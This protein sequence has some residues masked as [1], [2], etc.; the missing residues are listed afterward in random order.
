MNET[1]AVTV[2][3]PTWD[4]S[5]VL[6]RKCACGGS[7]SGK[8]ADCQNKK[9]RNSIAVAPDIAP[10]TAHNLRSSEPHSHLQSGPFPAPRF[11]HDFSRVRV[12]A[13]AADLG[14]PHVALLANELRSTVRDHR[15]SAL[16]RFLLPA[17]RPRLGEP[18]HANKSLSPVDLDH[19][20]SIGLDWGSRVAAKVFRTEAKVSVGATDS[21]RAPYPKTR[22]V[23]DPGDPDDPTLSA[24][25]GL[26]GCNLTLGLPWL[27]VTNPRCT[28]PCTLLHESTHFWDIAPCCVKAGIAYR[29]AP[30]AGKAAVAAAWGSWIGANRPWFECRAYRV[31]QT[32]GTA[33]NTMA[34]CW[35]PKSLVGKILVATGAA[36]GAIVG[37]QVLGGAGAVAG[38]ATGLAGGPAAPVTVPVGAGAGFITGELLGFLGG[39]GI[40]ALAGGAAEALRRACCEAVAK[41][42]STAASKI[43]KY[44]GAAGPTPCPF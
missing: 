15:G 27:I 29:A 25:N 42:R 9:S 36:T 16:S 26:T 39:A 21:A 35:A 22:E 41:Y 44:C 4:T 12:H 40:G 14:V 31:S 43:S 38:G 8:C 7:S 1:F 6:R 30:S 13:D 24:I 19:A 34:L 11:G 3:K 2:P 10:S 32:C 33:L 5:A 18:Q 20:R 17:N 28:A 23:D 37:S